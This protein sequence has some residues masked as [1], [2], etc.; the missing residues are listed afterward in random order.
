LFYR[1]ICVDFD[2]VIHSYTTKWTNATTIA[3]PPV[4]GAFAW[5]EGLLATMDQEPCLRPVVYSSRSKEPGAV[6]AMQAWFKQ[7]G[8]NEQLLAKLEFPTQKPS[9]FWALDDRCDRF[10][11]TFPSAAELADKKPWNKR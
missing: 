3:D 6:T 4:P 5:L 8:F 11:G 1:I 10:E 7:H 9:A 2:G